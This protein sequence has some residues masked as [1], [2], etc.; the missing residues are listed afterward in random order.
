[1]FR[2]FFPFNGIKNINKVGCQI[3]KM[4]V[5]FVIY[6]IMGK[7]LKERVNNF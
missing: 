6:Q 1:M 4:P 2:I 3:Y 5:I 7:S